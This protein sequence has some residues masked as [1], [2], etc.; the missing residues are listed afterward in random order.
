ML[1]RNVKNPAPCCPIGKEGWAGV[2]CV[3]GV[4]WG[5]GWRGRL[6]QV[7]KQL[8]ESVWVVRH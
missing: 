8:A 7:I 1:K 4:G 6:R 2:F 5:A 3:L